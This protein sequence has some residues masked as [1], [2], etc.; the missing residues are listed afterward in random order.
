MNTMSHADTVRE[1]CRVQF[2]EPA[3]ARKEETVTI[4]A[5]D[6]HSAIGFK[7][8]M[9]LV[10]SSLGTKLFEDHCGI[11]RIAVHGPLNGANAIFTFRFL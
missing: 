10:C 5:G 9:P 6:V 8:R 7:N 11:E 3:R 2:V 1:Y 4:R